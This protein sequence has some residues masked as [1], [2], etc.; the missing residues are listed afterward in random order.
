MLLCFQRIFERGV[1]VY[2]EVPFSYFFFNFFSLFL[3]TCITFRVGPDGLALIFHQARSFE[4]RVVH[5][6]GHY[7]YYVFLFLYYYYFK[8]ATFS[9]HALLW[10]KYD[11]LPFST[12]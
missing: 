2:I 1:L 9:D 10:I 3:F 12:I 6:Y 8:L 11:H 4:I 7:D 5:A